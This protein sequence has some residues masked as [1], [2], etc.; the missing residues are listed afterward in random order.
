V[1]YKRCEQNFNH[2][3][4]YWYRQDQGQGLQLIYYS[5][6]ENDIQKGDIPEGYNVIRKEKKFF[7]LILQES[8]TNQ[9]SL[10]LCANSR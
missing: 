3:A 4:M 10:Y 6:I 5:A 7:S 2:N 9:T 8:R 1:K